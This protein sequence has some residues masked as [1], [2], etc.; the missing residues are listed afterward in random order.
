[1]AT[2]P[3]VGGVVWVALLSMPLGVGDLDADLSWCMA[4][5][6]LWRSG[7]RCG[8]DWQFTYGPLGFLLSWTYDPGT[9][10]LKWWWEVAAKGW[11]TAVVLWWMLQLPRSTWMAGLFLTVA[12]FAGRWAD[13]LYPVAVCA[14]A[15]L[16]IRRR[17]GPALTA[18]MMLPWAAVAMT[19]FSFALT[20]G[21]SVAALTASRL[22][23]PSPRSAA[24]PPAAFAG[25][26][27][28]LWALAGQ[29]P[30]DIPAWVRSSLEISSGYAEAMAAWGD[31][32]EYVPAAV[33]TLALW[34]AVL[35]RRLTRPS[36]D[37]AAVLLLLAAGQFLAFKHGFV[38]HDGHSVGF[39]LHALLS[40]FLLPA[41]F[42]TT[43]W[44][45]PAR[46][47]LLSVAAGAGLCG[48]MM[49]GGTSY[50]GTDL[51]TRWQTHVR[52]QW[53]V[54][55]DPSAVRAEFER[56]AADLR[57]RAALPLV[58][59]EVGR[60]SIDSISTDQ[61]ILLLNGL[62]W[63]PRPV[64]QSYVA[65]T[66][67]LLAANAAYLSGPGAP[68]YLL[69]RVSPVDGR[70][71]TLEEGPGLWAVFRRYRLV[72]RDGDYLLL[73]RVAGI[74]T[75]L[76]DSGGGTALTV[77]PGEEVAVPSDGRWRELRLDVRPTAWGRLRGLLFKPPQVSIRLTR[78]DGR[79]ERFR[80]IP[81][82]ARAGFPLSPLFTDTA[83]TADILS[84]GSGVRV[85][86]FAV[87]TDSG[88]GPASYSTEIG[89]ELR[90]LNP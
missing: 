35:P 15:V 76:S 41:A 60:A 87:E 26:F 16:L 27:V 90:P 72:L 78:A 53:W 13:T 6:H 4:L 64:F 2:L 62:N 57:A 73:R 33:A 3:L 9:Y 14:S 7:L 23:G 48:L 17:G 42:P 18:A 37:T 49:A 24:V 88:R 85:R 79:V 69:F 50:G 75:P 46:R 36:A 12:V 47:T 51:P 29:S 38:R 65:F 71:P 61:G 25:W 28:L 39:F 55:T 82:M 34:T 54:L 5:P 83:S 52:I 40:A 43:G 67:A 80:L 63:K 1:L 56:L 59:A 86:S 10:A 21:L 8:V 89:V 19:K 81:A 74:G 11:M 84:G 30:A 70:L 20:A 77:A 45:S 44:A 22:A 66:P 31:R 58:A 68:D 32:R